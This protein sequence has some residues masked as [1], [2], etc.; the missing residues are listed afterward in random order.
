MSG[1]GLEFP[2]ANDGSG[3]IALIQELEDSIN[4]SIQQI[5]YTRK[6]ERVM[7]PEFGCDLWKINFMLNVEILKELSKEYIITSLSIWEKRIEVV[8]VQVDKNDEIVDISIT[9][10]IKNTNL[11]VQITVVNF[12]N[13]T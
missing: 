11:P 1:I 4:S 8:D 7:N 6:G 2:F 9:Y 3:S 12:A 5:I 13:Q 10:F